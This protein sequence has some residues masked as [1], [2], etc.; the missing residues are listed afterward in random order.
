MPDSACDRKGLKKGQVLLWLGFSIQRDS[1]EHPVS[2]RTIRDY[3]Q[4]IKNLHKTLE[5]LGCI[6]V[7]KIGVF[8]QD[9]KQ[10]SNKKN[11]YLCIT[12]PIRIR[13]TGQQIISQYILESMTQLYLHRYFP[14]L[15]SIV[16]FLRKLLS[17]HL[18]T[19]AH[20]VS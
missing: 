2:R 10:M 17:Y 9:P 15:S 8:K 13:P 12:D 14:I 18:T 4:Q 5:T 6:S 11:H 19:C 7:C 16:F 3:H 20:L 1:L